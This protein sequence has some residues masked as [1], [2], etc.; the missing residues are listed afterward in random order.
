MEKKIT[1][2]ITSIILFV[3]I[4]ALIDT[5]ILLITC[6]AFDSLTVSDFLGILALLLGIDLILCIIFLII[7][8]VFR[9]RNNN[10]KYDTTTCYLTVMEKEHK[11]SSSSVTLTNIGGHLYPQTHSHPEEFNV[12]FEYQNDVYSIDDEEL[13]ERC[14]KGDNVN[15]NINTGYN[16]KGVVKNIYL[17]PAE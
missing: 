17:S 10:L 14:N 4:L 11:D 9:I 15:V 3:A 7:E 16:K 13:F 5:A 12:Y 1:N 2:V 8:C 6:F